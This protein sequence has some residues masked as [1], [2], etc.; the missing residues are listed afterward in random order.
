MLVLQGE[1]ILGYMDMRCDMFK[2][3]GMIPR[4]YTCD[5]EDCMPTLTISDVPEKT[6]SLALII[7]DPDASNGGV[8][9]HCVAYNIPAD[10]DRLDAGVIASCASGVNSWGNTGYGGPCPPR[11]ARAHRYIFT[12]YALDTMFDFSAPPDTK[13]F[14]DTIEGHSI[15]QADYMGLYGR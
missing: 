9:N 14:M 7:D 15:G 5:G 8:W 2:N 12:L 6:V 1:C 3:G 10:T 13:Q 11:G 4:E